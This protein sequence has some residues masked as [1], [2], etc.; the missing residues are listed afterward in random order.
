[1]INEA[2]KPWALEVGELLAQAAGLCVEHGLDADTFMKGAWS[3]YVDARP[4]LREYIEEMQLRAQL[5]EL[6]K[7][8]RIPDA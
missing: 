4:G 2:P 5:D 1:M 6:R 7:S 8:G 3:A